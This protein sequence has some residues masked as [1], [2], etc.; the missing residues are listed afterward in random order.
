MRMQRWIQCSLPFAAVALIAAAPMATAGA[1]QGQEVFEWN[2]QVD[3]EVQI[4]V[5]DND[6][7]T[8]RVGN[9]EPGRPRVRSVSSLPRQDGTLSVQVLNGRGNVNIIQQPNRSNSYTAI[10]RVEDPNGGSAPYRIVGYWQSYANGDIYRNR[11][12]DRGRGR[13]DD[14]DRNPGG[15]YG[16]NRP[17]ES[18]LHWSGNVDGEV[19]LRIQNGRIQT[20]NLS[21]NQPTSIRVN[22]GYMNVPRTNSSVGVAMNQGRGQVFV[23]EQPSARNGYTTVI[24]IRDPQGGYGYYDFDLMWQ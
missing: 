7:R 21:G 17:N 9:N 11:G 18:M 12:R 6:V 16:A 15:V 10:V 1:Q 14:N 24:R 13:V 8:N 20:R 23:A 5:R 4:V 3:R 2:G 22:N 19:E